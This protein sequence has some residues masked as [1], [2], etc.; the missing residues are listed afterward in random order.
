M[1]HIEGGNLHEAAKGIRG[2][3]VERAGVEDVENDLR[4]QAV[5]YVVVRTGM[6]CDEGTRLHSL[7]S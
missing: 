6:R 7:C 4:T 1:G 3:R 2:G 5:G